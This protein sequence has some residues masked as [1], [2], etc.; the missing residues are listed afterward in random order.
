M[1]IES[2][3]INVT[4]SLNDWKQGDAG[5][6][7]A[8]MPLIYDELCQIARG[9]LRKERAHHTFKTQGLVHEAYL[10]LNN[11]PG[12]RFKSRTHFY[13][14]AA[15]TMRQVLVDH[16]REHLAEK[17]GGR[18]E[19]VYVEDIDGLH[20]EDPLDL[21]RLD[22]ALEELGEFDQEKALMVDMRYFGGLTIEETAELLEVSPA[23]LKR[24]WHFTKAWLARHMDL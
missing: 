11:Q 6:G 22:K 18:Y 15:R 8:V 13:G 12:V 17:R 19:R 7:N 2:G 1:T 9:Q 5:A 16:A 10:R 21:L 24:D 14:I 20:E 4:G 23:T 3:H